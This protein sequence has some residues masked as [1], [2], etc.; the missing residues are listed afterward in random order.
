MDE[1]RLPKILLNYKLGGH[2]DTAKPET[3]WKYKLD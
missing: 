3:R 1:M 2:K